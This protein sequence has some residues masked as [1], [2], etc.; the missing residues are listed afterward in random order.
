VQ[1]YVSTE[2]AKGVTVNIPASTSSA[3]GGPPST[4][5]TPEKAGAHSPPKK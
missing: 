2:R 1:N 4:K 5:A 3:G